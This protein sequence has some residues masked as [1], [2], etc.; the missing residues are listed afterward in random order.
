MVS[1]NNSVRGGTA[2]LPGGGG[3]TASP[4][5]SVRGGS[6]FLSLGGTDGT[7]SAGT[8]LR[9][10]QSGSSVVS[11]APLEP[12]RGRAPSPS[13]SFRALALAAP[14][15]SPFSGTEPADSLYSSPL[16]ATAASSPGLRPADAIVPE[17]PASGAP[18]PGPSAHAEPASQAAI[19][20]EVRHAAC[21][22]TPST[23]ALAR[24]GHAAPGAPGPGPSAHQ[25]LGARTVGASVPAARGNSIDEWDRRSSVLSGDSRDGAPG[26]ANEPVA[27][28]SIEA[29][30]THPYRLRFLNDEI[31]EMC[32]FGRITFFLV[33][34]GG[35]EGGEGF[36]V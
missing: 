16:P 23:G 32:V 10:K 34:D 29:I 35:G 8:S 5:V 18:G 15:P 13:E 36:R 20:P 21:A 17:A 28:V 30:A 27:S 25:G 31:E 6:S 14:R 2:F 11:A 19:A 1:P 4:N 26:R 33:K 3:L 24:P 22:L 7:S 9:S 12:G